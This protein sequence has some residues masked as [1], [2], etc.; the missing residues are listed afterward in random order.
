MAGTLPPGPGGFPGLNDFRWI[1][2]PV[3]LQEMAKK[4][5]GD[6][7]SLQLARDQWVLVSRP[8][9]INQVF[10]T[11]PKVLHGG[12]GN[13]IAVS[14]LGRT[15]VLVADEDLHAAERKVLRPFLH[16]DRLDRYPELMAGICEEQVATWP[17]NQPFPLLQRLEAIAVNII[18]N[19]VFGLRS[20][21]H[22][23]ELLSRVRRL[24]AFGDSP[25]RMIGFFMLAA[26][27]TGKAPKDFL[28]RRN[29]VDEQIY[30]ELDR[31]RNDPSLAERDDVL[32]MLL[33]ARHDD[34]SALS[35]TELRD[36][37][38]T[39][40][41]Q[42]HQSTATTLAWALERLMR[43]PV[44]FDR[45][46]AEAPTDSDDYVDLVFR[47]TLRLRPPLP[48][49]MRLVKEPYTLGGYQLDPDVRIAILTYQLHRRPEFYPQ[50]ERFWPERFLEEPGKSAM[51]I[52]FGGGER[53]CIG[54]S[55]ATM[56]VKI[57]LRTLALQTRMR[58]P[59][60]ADEGVKHRRVQ[61]SPGR[62]AMTIITE[63]DQSVHTNLSP[64]LAQGVHTS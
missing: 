41:I 1:F 59:D 44:E 45:L 22:Y 5:Y 20:G 8:E 31:A 57:V 51:W 56:V 30:R 53:H 29:A 63:R 55:F 12:E 60:P 58:P 19:V 37:L 34:G 32:A 48:V 50:P 10:K 13:N 18:M 9:L 47:E 23:H 49:T 46:R 42:G 54:R 11:D 36:Q 3:P 40:L 64:F 28:A 27:G 17:L 43:H 21:P 7:W 38:V 6:L 25:I 24:I 61:F 26:S 4:R 14:L 2:R 52:P 33:R 62:N 35:N 39:L 16:G 15:S